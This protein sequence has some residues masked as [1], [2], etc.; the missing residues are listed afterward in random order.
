MPSL[1]QAAFLEEAICSVLSQNYPNLEFMVL[2]GGSI[3]GS[4]RIIERYGDS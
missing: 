2:D 4:Q 1:N 3:D